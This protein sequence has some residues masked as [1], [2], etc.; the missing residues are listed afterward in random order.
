MERRKRTAGKSSPIPSDYSKMVADVF[1]SNF[2]EGLKK[3]AKLKRG[4]AHFEVNGAIYLDE[5]VLSVSLLIGK[6]LA[7]T[8]VYASTDYDPRASVP[9][10]QDLMAACVDAIG[11]IFA[12][13]LIEQTEALADQSLSALSKVPFHWTEVAVERFKVHVKIDKSNP[14]LDR[15]ADDWLERNDPARKA[16]AEEEHR[17]TEK[18]FMTG[19]EQ[20]AKVTKKPGGGRVH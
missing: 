1:A 7:A 14:N 20:K 13:L 15:L 12:P 11:G 4:T 2:D 16:E 9:Q 10:V 19:A 17:E 8:T 18:L 3:I 6:E 5:V